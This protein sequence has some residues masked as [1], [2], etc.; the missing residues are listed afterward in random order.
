MGSGRSASRKITPDA[1]AANCIWPL[2]VCAGIIR[3][4]TAR[5]TKNGITR[6]AIK[7]AI[8]AITSKPALNRWISSA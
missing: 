1:Q 8:S 7:S 5:I 6:L 3:P 2:R 4:V